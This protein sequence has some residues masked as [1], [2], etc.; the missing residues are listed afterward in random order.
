MK[1]KVPTILPHTI[2]ATGRKP[3]W[4][5]AK[6]LSLLPCHHSGSTVAM[7]G[8]RSSLLWSV[9]AMGTVMSVASRY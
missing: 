5:R 4:P 9:V 6:G 3:L 2:V 8:S 1:G 7:G